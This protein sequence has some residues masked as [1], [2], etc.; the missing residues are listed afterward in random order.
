MI[1]V[2]NTSYNRKEVF[3]M[4]ETFDILITVDWVG[5]LLLGIPLLVMTFKDLIKTYM[6]NKNKR[7]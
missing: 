2:I 3:K 1:R 6:N 4:N 7:G 5:G